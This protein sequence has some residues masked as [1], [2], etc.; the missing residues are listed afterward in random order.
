LFILLLLVDCIFSGGKFLEE[1]S[2]GVA[3]GAVDLLAN[4]YTLALI[5]LFMLVLWRHYQ[6]C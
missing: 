6:L 5:L 2:S 4:C 1:L 3:A